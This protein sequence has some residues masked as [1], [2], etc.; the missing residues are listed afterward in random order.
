MN[1]VGIDVSK[2]KSTVA[3]MR[4]FGEVV[5]EPFEVLHTDTELR[6]L[7]CFLEK[8][9][10]DSKTAFSR[11]ASRYSE[12][13]QC[14][15]LPRQRMKWSCHFMNDFSHP[16][17]N[18]SLS[19]YTNQSSSLSRLH[20]R[21]HA[22]VTSIY[23]THRRSPKLY[24]QAIIPSAF[25]IIT[26]YSYLRLLFLLDIPRQPSPCSTRRIYGQVLPLSSEIAIA[27]GHL[28]LGHTVV[29]TSSFIF[30]GL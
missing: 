19:H 13:S 30:T 25:C 2:G 12:V 4:P 22:S 16:F 28:S 21:T 7:A 10:G 27:T 14:L 8:L 9:P 1:A 15:M 6:K 3:I 23:F 18:S 5:A 20:P 26:G 11:P 17:C 24:A 29:F